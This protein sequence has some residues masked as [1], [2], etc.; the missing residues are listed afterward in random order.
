LGTS[1]GYTVVAGE[2]LTHYQRAMSRQAKRAEASISLKDFEEEDAADLAE[3]EDQD[4]EEQFEDMLEEKRI[5]TIWAEGGKK[6]DETLRKLIKL[7]GSLV[8]KF[9]DDEGEMGLKKIYQKLP[10]AHKAVLKA[11]V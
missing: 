3:E 11:R 2:A 10:N 8:I 4:G 5:S 6:K 9:E 1:I 7:F